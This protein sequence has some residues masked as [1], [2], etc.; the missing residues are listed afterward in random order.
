M[1]LIRDCNGL[2]LYNFKGKDPL[3]VFKVSAQRI[4]GFLEQG[5]VC[6][7]RDVVIDLKTGKKTT[8][9]PSIPDGQG[10]KQR[11]ERVCLSADGSTLAALYDTN[12]VYLFDAQKLLAQWRTKQN[13]QIAKQRKPG[14]P[15]AKKSPAKK[16][17]GKTMA[18]WMAQLQSGD[19]NKRLKAGQAL[20]KFGKKPVPQLIKQ[21]K[22][23]DVARRRRAAQALGVIGP[24]AKDAIP[25]LKEA[26][27]DVDERVRE[28]A[29]DALKKIESSN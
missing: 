26:I 4:C 25:Q 16:V 24:N 6:V 18:E 2:Q 19:R 20:A 1:V 13:A 22:H 15:P 14:T 5:R 23:K 21:L 3:K 11:A 7:V 10:R 12:Q 9:L 28:Y 27:E 29:R 17:R 8:L